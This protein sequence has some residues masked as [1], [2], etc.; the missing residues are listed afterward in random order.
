MSTRDQ[1]KAAIFGQ[2][3]G[4]GA[5]DTSQANDQGARGPMQ[6][7][8]DTFNGLK[9]SGLIPQN[10][11]HSNPAHTTE[12]GNVL[13]DSLF[14][15]YGDDRPDQVAAA[16]YGGPK[17]ILPNGSIANFGN[18]KHPD[19]PKVRDY[20]AQVLGRMGM[21]ADFSDDDEAQPAQRT[22]LE[23]AKTMNPQDI[24]RPAPAVT[25]RK[26][27]GD[28][29][30][31]M[32]NTTLGAQGTDI[33]QGVQA[34]ADADVAARKAQADTPEGEV[35]SSIIMN[36]PIG[37]AIKWYARP[38]YE[39]ESGFK[40]NWD[41]AREKL[42]TFTDPEVA[43]L[44]QSVSQESQSAL[45]NEILMNRETAKTA[46]YR[47]GLY[48]GA[49][50]FAVNLPAY[51]LPGIGTEAGLTRLGVGAA[52]LAARGSLGAARFSAVAEQVAANTLLT[53]VQ[54]QIDPYVTSHN[55]FADAGMGVIGAGFMM[56]GIN[57]AAAAGAEMRAAAEMR[58]T[59]L[60][61]RA[62]LEAQARVNLG[63]N[64]TGEQLAK[65]VERIESQQIQDTL[66][67]GAQVGEN[68]KVL[69]VDVAS[70]TNQITEEMKAAEKEGAKAVPDDTA[71]VELRDEGLGTNGDMEAAAP[72]FDAKTTGRTVEEILADESRTPDTRSASAILDGI[73]ASK[74]DPLASTLA[75]R[76]R[77]HL[78]T[79]DINVHFLS[80]ED[81]VKVA[82]Q[83][84]RVP[85]GFYRGNQN[86]IVVNTAH[87]ADPYL[88]LHEIAHGLSVSRLAAGQRGLDPTLT[89]LSMD[90]EKMRVQAKAKLDQI[91]ADGGSING[92]RPMAG[93]R[94]DYYLSNSKEFVAGLYSGHGMFN[95][96]LKGIKVEGEQSFY[97]K[98]VGKV[99]KLLG[100]NKGD[101][102][103]AFTH[104]L[105]KSDEL[106][107]QKLK[108]TRTNKVTGDVSTAD[109]A[110]PAGRHPIVM[111]Y[112]LDTLP[113]E[114]ASQKAE[115]EAMAR[116]YQK[117]EGTPVAD[118]ARLSK[119][120][121]TSV[122]QGGQAI[123]NVMA[124]S[125]NPLVR[126]LSQRLLENP[127]GSLGR[128]STAAMTKF[129]EE[130]K[131]LGNV[132]NDYESY[133]KNY[134]RDA[135][136]TWLQGLTGK[137]RGPF[138]RLVAQE[139]ESRRDGAM[140]IVSHPAVVKAA[141]AVEAA[142]KR[143]L[144]AQ[145]N[146]KTLGYQ[147]LPS[148]SKGYMPHRMGTGQVL[149]MSNEER[150]FLNSAL[151][152]QFQ[153]IS[154]FDKEF[155]DK[156]AIKY[157]DRVRERALGGYDAPIGVYQVG[158]SD[159]VEQ[160]L[161]ELGFTEDE[162]QTAL[163]RYTAG[164]ASHTKQRLDLDL[165][166]VYTR[167]DGT[168]FRLMDAMN[169]DQMSLLRSM[170]GRVSG[171]VALAKFGLKGKP[172]LDMIRRAI[173]LGEDGS[174]RTA[175]DVIAETKAFDQMVAEFM[176]TPYGTQNKNLNRLMLANVLTRMG[177]AVWSQVGEGIQALYH[178]GAMRSIE[179]VAGVPRLVSEIHTLAKGGKVD[180]PLIGSIETMS[181]VDFGL[182]S[183]RMNFPNIGLDD[184]PTYGKD[185]M[186]S[187]D[188][189]LKG[190]V[191]LQG[192]I[193][194]WRTVHSAQQ[195]GMAEQIVA[196]AG[197]YIM[198][199]RNDAALR[200]MGISDK[201]A[202]T[203]RDSGAFEMQGG[204][205]VGF[206]IS[207]VKD[208]DAA[209]QFVQSIHRGTSQIIQG[210]F[211]GERGAWAHDGLMRMLT[212]FRTF[213][214][215]SVEKQWA[216]QV[217]NHGPYAALGLLIGSMSVAAPL[218]A[219]RVY[220]SSIGRDD[221]DEYI[222]KHLTPFNIAKQTL[223]YVGMSGLAGDALDIFS[224][225]TGV[226]EAEGGRAKAGGTG[227]IGNTL[228][229]AAGTLD[230]FYKAL[231]PDADGHYKPDQML[232][233]LPFGRVP[234]LL[235]AVQALGN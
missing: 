187:L 125:K 46:S 77:Q 207:K 211:I 20:V 137:E 189:L 138:D 203:L 204:K 36:G 212:Q 234:A 60:A 83:Q 59:A 123:A 141:D 225:L 142:Y 122:F 94:A 76:L 208:L 87:A 53:G 111:K 69:D 158:S 34:K 235:P 146:A 63:A 47:G 1:L 221:A 132:G 15:K 103:D 148:D 184:L 97:S 88:H 79:N 17:A 6:V 195:R 157:T 139:I 143:M 54:A 118:E 32:P 107:S 51:V 192:R 5:A 19:H 172:D 13:I 197:D 190:G 198:S 154:G 62:G 61:Q 206:D 72:H 228:G 74:D 2:E 168:E 86:E 173:Q 126:F 14:D 220:A 185:T 171:E 40:L 179:S 33:Y 44:N 162:V 140:Q 144:D 113:N 182:D 26:M 149:A 3:S 176:N 210:T 31:V 85:R 114:T 155:A 121:N 10:Y 55:F 128:N 145:V 170:S 93:G 73:A 22:S 229:P 43:L 68:G 81:A 130:R 66:T 90:I 21:Q 233:L 201:L 215:T 82:D 127:S 219:A 180:N 58:N 7:T 64:A 57:R 124:R 65:E 52:Q 231:Q 89:K 134:A 112:G 48:E 100:I 226:G 161:R 45:T 183:H 75:A 12:A 217:G 102:L 177:G 99:A 91:I 224:A 29:L 223:N 178:L 218:Y 67:Q 151:S 28:N 167:A 110:A 117:A 106:M 35:V 156:L 101:E 129:L 39:N 135:G 38:T 202:K 8:L 174:G 222:E 92:Q 119:L 16:Y 108:V 232:K 194:L 80:P 164:R 227:L 181:G 188:K 18:L 214:I 96:L 133:Y 159:L 25:A 27:P 24:G 136:V 11:D 160:A 84:G 41:K 95:D 153:T 205:T 169:T 131:Y 98:F 216:R 104:M 78:G 199:G 71:K 4:S 175:E 50:D 209:E 70:R 116:A 105:N 115:V 37:S 23:Q 166:K 56:R 109:F 163:R 213:S 49:V 152:E 147:A 196:K 200:D 193:S 42:G 30:R 150:R 165:N 9:A 186:T 120:M 230:D 191:N